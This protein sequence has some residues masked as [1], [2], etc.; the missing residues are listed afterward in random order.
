MAS[1]VWVPGRNLVSKA[2]RDPKFVR[3]SPFPYLTR[4]YNWFWQLIDKTTLRWDENTKLIM[5]EGGSS[6]P[7]KTELAKA[8]AREFGMAHMPAPS[9]DEYF[10]RTQD[11]QDF[12]IHNEHFMPRNRPYAEPEF[13]AAPFGSYKGAADRYFYL[14]YLAKFTN[15]VFAMR[16]MFNTGEGVVVEGNPFSSF[17]HMNAA[18][19]SNYISPSTKEL[20]QYTVKIKHRDLLRPNVILHLDIDTKKTS[21]TLKKTYGSGQVA[22]KDPV[23]DNLS[24]LNDISL[25]LNREYLNEAKK[26]SLV[27][28]YDW[29][30]PGENEIIVEDMERL[31]LDWHNFGDLQQN[32]WD[33]KVEDKYEKDSMDAEHLIISAEEIINIDHVLDALDSERFSQ[34]WNPYNGD[35]VFFKSSTGAIYIK[36]VFYNKVTVGNIHSE[37]FVYP[38]DNTSK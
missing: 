35:N 19:R 33:L 21:D 22:V 29:N 24:F 23:W 25:G 5:V 9:V 26:H 16:H 8:L 37:G 2:F 31:D 3:K 28:V 34:G 27:L 32:D 15:Y 6:S 4:N 14:D 17:A 10:F 18:L 38:E 12:R 13:F 7:E 1:C 11:R 20:F 30:E 36:P